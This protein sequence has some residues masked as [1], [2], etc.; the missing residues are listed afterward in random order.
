MCVQGRSWGVDVEVVEN[1]GEEE[2]EGMDKEMVDE[3]QK[4]V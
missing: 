1:V 2:M 3:G 4:A